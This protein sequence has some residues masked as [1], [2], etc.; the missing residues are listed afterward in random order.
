MVQHKGVW[1]DDTVTN[2]KF[3]KEVLIP[4]G[5]FGVFLFFVLSGFLITTILL[6]QRKED[7]NRYSA[8]KN[9]FIRRALR[10]FPIYFLL[11][12]FLYITNYPE[13]RANI[14]YHATYTTNILCYIKNDWN[15]F[16]H[17]WTLSV[18]EQFYLLWPW[19][20]VFTPARWLKPL[21]MTSII[22][23]MV[24]T[25]YCLSIQGRIGPF[26]PFN[27][28]DS[29]GIG[30]LFAY[31][32]T[33]A[34][35]TARFNTWINRTAVLALAIYLYWK[36]AAFFQLPVYGIEFVK[37]VESILAVK[38]ISL[39]V[40]ASPSAFRRHF[41]ENRALMFIG[42]VSYGIYLYHYI[43]NTLVYYQLNSYLEKISAGYPTING[44]VQDS[45]YYYWLHVVLTI[46]LATASYYIIERP[47]LALKKYFAYKPGA[48]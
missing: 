41:L 35:D 15:S 12:S 47:F 23:G 11:L 44:W 9:F 24:T 36:L 19:L 45:H 7:C 28:F 5:G 8:I 13:I 42:K 31:S 39:V 27:C 17:A 14:W 3:I 20:I 38:L 30:A 2:G 22:T 16:S 25:W 26:L 34:A 48:V 37:G 10:I 40:N 33:N 43:Y 1:F 18:E 46:L 4:D 29:F 6:H 21:L 32:Q